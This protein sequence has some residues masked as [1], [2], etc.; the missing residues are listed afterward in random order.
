MMSSLMAAPFKFAADMIPKPV[1]GGTVRDRVE[2]RDSSQ[3]LEWK[4][5][6]QPTVGEKAFRDA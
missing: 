4:S 1:F 2:T 5:P 3:F 6:V